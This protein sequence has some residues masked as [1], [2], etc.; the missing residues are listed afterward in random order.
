MCG[1]VNP[2]M[3]MSTDPQL[4]DQ[5]TAMKRRRQVPI[6]CRFCREKKLK[7]DRQT[8]CSNCSFRGLTCS[9]EFKSQ[10]P[11]RSALPDISE[12][13]AVLE[14]LRRLE[15]VV[16]SQNSSVTSN[17]NCSRPALTDTTI[18]SAN[19][20]RPPGTQIASHVQNGLGEQEVTYCHETPA[21]VYR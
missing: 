8:P 6:S 10:L 3:A 20:W 7:C 16:F 5:T 4:R 19:L 13:A 14:R 9:N 15:E 21:S 12:K 11:N 18:G 1:P 17:G 2:S